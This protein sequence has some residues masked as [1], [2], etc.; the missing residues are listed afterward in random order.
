MPGQA[1]LTAIFRAA[2]FWAA[3]SAGQSFRK[4][5]CV[6]AVEPEKLL[7]NWLEPWV[8]VES[9]GG[10]G[11][12]SCGRGALLP[13]SPAPCRLESVRTPAP[14]TQT[15]SFVEMNGAVLGFSAWGDDSELPPG[16]LVT[17]GCCAGRWKLEAVGFEE[18]RDIWG[19]RQVL[20]TLSQ[21]SVISNF[22]RV[23]CHIFY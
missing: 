5:K 2:G 6:G 1:V 3:G 17:G 14:L 16:S 10:C 4:M 23:H 9:L 7:M 13:T 19:Q 8:H 21:C 18:R 15:S 22:H 11:L 12:E 20:H